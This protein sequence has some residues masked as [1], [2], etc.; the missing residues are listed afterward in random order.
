MSVAFGETIGVLMLRS[1]SL[2]DGIT[3][4][5]MFVGIAGYDFR[6]KI[7]KDALQD[8]VEVSA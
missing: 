5:H 3:L 4:G 6:V 8:S 1:F 2:N 7:S